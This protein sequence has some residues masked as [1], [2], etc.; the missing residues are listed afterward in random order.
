MARVDPDH[1]RIVTGRVVRQWL[2]DVQRL[3]PAC[4]RAKVVSLAHAAGA[5]GTAV[6]L[7]ALILRQLGE[8]SDQGLVD[9]VCEVWAT[10]TDQ[11][12]LD[13]LIGDRGWI[14]SGPAPLRVRTALFA[15]R[16]EA[17]ADGDREVARDLVQLAEDKLNLEQSRL[18]RA[19]LEQLRDQQAREE[20]CRAAVEDGSGAALAAAVTA[21]FRPHD[22]GRLAA[23]LYL[24]GNPEAYAELDYDGAL[25]RAVHAAADP[26]LRQRL[27]TVARQSGR[28]DWVRA[29]THPDG[30]A[31]LSGEEWDTGTRI[32][33]EG[34][35]WSDLW[36]LALAAP[37]QRAAEL[38]RVIDASGWAPGNESTRSDFTTLADL[39]RVCVGPPMQ[40]QLRPPYTERGARCQLAVSAD[41]RLLVAGGHGGKVSLWR[42]PSAAPAGTIDATPGMM[43][44]LAISPDGRLLAVGGTSSLDLWHLPSG[45]SAGRLDRRC[46]GVGF[47]PDGSVLITGEHRGPTRM[48]TL[49]SLTPGRALLDHATVSDLV[50]GPAGHAVVTADDAIT[51]WSVPSGEPVG[52][53]GPVAIERPLAFGRAGQ[54]AAALA[55]GSVRF[56]R[57][58]SDRAEA[59]LPGAPPADAYR[60]QAVS[61]L[62]IT[63]DGHL[64]G[65]DQAGTIRL[66]GPAAAAPV[67]TLDGHRSAITR[68]AVTVQGALLFSA[69]AAGRVRRWRLPSG[70]DAGVVGT[71]GSQV[72]S[73]LA[74]PSGELVA[75]CDD[76]SVHLWS[77]LLTLGAVPVEQIGPATAHAL[78]S[79]IDETPGE[80]QWIELICTLVRLRHRYDIEV[81]GADR[82][83]D[84]YTFDD[85]DAVPD[86]EVIIRGM[87][88]S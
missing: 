28:L 82:D 65:G 15:R 48:W 63:P 88:R 79:Q 70:E 38:L 5:F 20:V 30:L 36:Q 8:L 27:A 61:A 87:E 45:E 16:P 50:I 83:T 40:W 56:W 7:R 68:L 29:V 31:T 55:D 52:I 41:A 57:L 73:L 67:R 84:R 25:L 32:L 34:R 64:V 43:T 39:A 78:S 24:G 37:P 46:G 66:W 76:G 74:L 75:G 12:P 11:Q 54:F 81:D 22:P 18:A 72:T 23:L 62:A 9:A 60:P 2:R 80:R 21:G 10:R 47:S 69:D 1:G 3:P 6:K 85:L 59:I 44:C 51:A 86:A 17:L 19:A 53:L 35:R 77:R 58:P 49:P 71:L 26:A 33:I 42:L 13:Q 14:A 4:S